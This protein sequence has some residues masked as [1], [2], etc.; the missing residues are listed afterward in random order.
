MADSA[1]ITSLC[2]VSR[3]YAKAIIDEYE[4]TQQEQ[5]AFNELTKQVGKD[6]DYMDITKEI[7]QNM[8][9][10]NLDK[11]DEE[12]SDLVFTTELRLLK[13]GD[14]DDQMEDQDE[15]DI[16]EGSSESVSSFGDDQVDGEPKQRKNNRDNYPDE[17]EDSEEEKEDYTIRKSDALIVAATAENDHSNLEVYIYDHKTSDLYVHH[18]I[19]LSSYPL[20]ME[21]M[22]SL[23]GQKCN[24]VVV[25]TFLPE[26]EVWDLNKEDCEPVFTL[27]GLPEGTGTSKKKKKQLMNKFNKSAEQQQFNSESHTDAVMTLSINPFQ[28]EY[29]A[30]GSADTTVR[31]WDL[32]EQACKAT[33]TNLHKN[34]VQVVRWNLHNES[35]LLTGGYDRV[36]NVVDVRESPLGEGALKFRLKKEVKDLE[37]AQW[38]PSYEHNFVISTESGIV[39]GYDTRNPKEAL[40]EMQAHEKSCT[41]VTISPHAPNMMATCSLDEYVKVWDVA[42][43]GQPKLVGYRKMGMGELFSLSYYKDIPWVLAAGGSKGELAVWDT[44]ESDKIKEHFTPFIDSKYQKAKNDEEE[45]EVEMAGDESDEE[46]KKSS[47][48]KDKKVA[49]SKVGKDKSK[50]KKKKV[51]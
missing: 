17:L 42:A 46:E 51:Q 32:E 41:N 24:Y 16:E 5:K 27:G 35:I 34:K 37:T 10:L 45:E 21:W 8:D 13:K 25:G 29:L 15:D 2:W 50:L 44:E 40:F 31:I 33:F 3:G 12:E 6:K 18:E 26:I 36:L 9:S 7:Q 43:A 38:H 22:H 47:S 49:K 30:S 28:S 20:C 11:Y 19:I 14:K 1:I 4:P 23:G 48:K 39:V